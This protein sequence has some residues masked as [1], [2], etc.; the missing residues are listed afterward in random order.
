MSDMLWP[1]LEQG[2]SGSSQPSSC[3]HPSLGSGAAAPANAD[4]RGS[5]L[6]AVIFVP[7]YN[8]FVSLSL[9]RIK[10]NI[11]ESALEGVV[12]GGRNKKHRPRSDITMG[13]VSAFCLVLSAGR[14]QERPGP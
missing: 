8:Y 10:K 1:C 9:R 13:N 4:S 2:P 12:E 11:N 3:Q 5:V 14:S 7:K 6:L